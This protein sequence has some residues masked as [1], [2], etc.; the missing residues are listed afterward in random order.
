MS[1]IR[2]SCL[3]CKYRK[4]PIKDNPCNKGVAKQNE[5]II[6]CLGWND[7][8]AKKGGAAND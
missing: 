7:R 2:N 4:L 8:R 6:N 3:T 5:L 1:I